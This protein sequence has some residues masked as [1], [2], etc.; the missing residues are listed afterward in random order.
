MVAKHAMRR[1]RLRPRLAIIGVSIIA[2]GGGVAALH[3][4]RSTVSSVASTT[5]TAPPVTT[6]T[7]PISIA[8]VGDTELGNSPNV[9]TNPT[10]QLAPM[11]RLLSAAI[12][13]GNLEG[14]LT[15]ATNSKCGAPSSS[16]YAFRTP[17]SFAEAYRRAGFT[18]LNSANNHS[19][20][21]GS[22]GLADTSAALRAAGIVQ[23]GLPGQIG[24]VHR[25]GVTVAFVDFAPYYLTNNLLVPSQLTSLVAIAKRHAA[26]VVVY[27]HSG[28]EGTTADHV[29]RTSEYYYGENRG[30]PY[31][32]AHA[33]IDAGANLVLGSGPH[34]W[35]GMEWYRG[36]LIVYSMGDFT[37]FGNFASVGDLA[38]TG[39]VHVELSS[40]GR[41]LSGSLAP[42]LME[43]GGLVV[44][45]PTHQLWGFVNALSRTDFHNQ[46]ALV[47]GAGRIIP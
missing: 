7:L 39:V 36:R 25:K 34:V 14:T 9:P 10:S 42:A 8:A 12:T 21:F 3:A 4:L 28:A 19:F 40:T 44:P 18:V 41:F 2:L 32:F 1:S 26:I 11:K 24:Y 46:A 16:C 22:Q 20:D 30:N 38:I 6:T 47:D 45:D 33:A 15:N 27:M 23:A 37:N 5:T 43:P 29:T 17:P 13:F 35:R 31:A